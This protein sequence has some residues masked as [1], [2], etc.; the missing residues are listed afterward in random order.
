MEGV[1]GVVRCEGMHAHLAVGATELGDELGHL[2]ASGGDA[3]RF[4]A[5]QHLVDAQRLAAV[6]CSVPRDNTD[7][8]QSSENGA[9]YSQ[10][11]GPRRQQSR[12][13]RMWWSS[14]Q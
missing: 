10:L 2:N 7:T 4:E 13:Q 6:L 12:D 5:V 11:R 8:K 3:E 14:R 9:I 1:E